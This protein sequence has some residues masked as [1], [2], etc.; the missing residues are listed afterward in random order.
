MNVMKFLNSIRKNVLANNSSSE[1]DEIPVAKELFIDETVPSEGSV[2]SS[3]GSVLG[4]DAVY[5]FLEADYE[6]RGYDDALTNPD[7]SYKNDNLRLLSQDLSILIKKVQIY[8]EG[9]QRKLDF[10]ISTRSRAGLIDLVEELRMERENVQR[11]IDT[12]DSIGQDASKH[13]G[14]T[15]RISLSY[16]RGFARGLAAIT[17]ADLL[18]TKL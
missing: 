1:V 18:T 3:S 10:H 2:G 13:N 7:N 8:Y 17:K 11:H 6:P 4:L 12:L 15:E 5:L 14:L 9:L 16:Q